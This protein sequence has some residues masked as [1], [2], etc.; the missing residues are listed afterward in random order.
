MPYL[1]DQA[2]NNWGVSDSSVDRLV[3]FITN[4]PDRE[5]QRINAVV[6]NMPPEFLETRRFSKLCERI[7][8]IQALQQPSHP[9]VQGIQL[10]PD[11]S[12]A[13]NQMEP[14]QRALTAQARQTLT[15]S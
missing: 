13:T 14:L 8:A 11:V 15:F 1:V 6:Q 3:A 12:E 4:V 9:L 2:K 5:E 7:E 10:E